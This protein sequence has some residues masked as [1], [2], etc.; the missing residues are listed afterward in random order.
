QDPR[1]RVN[2]GNRHPVRLDIPRTNAQQARARIGLYLASERADGD[3][4]D[5]FR[6][7]LS[8]GHGLRT[9]LQKNLAE[10]VGSPLDLL[11]VDAGQVPLRS[12]GIALVVGAEQV[13][14]LVE[15]GE[16]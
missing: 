10:A 1:E 9:I 12:P 5:V 3:I 14:P 8:R 7:G 6:K 2:Q 13:R 11:N 4:R 16:D 15:L